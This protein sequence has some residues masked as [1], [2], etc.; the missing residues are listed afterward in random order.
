M[1]TKSNILWLLVLIPVSLFIIICSAYGD[2]KVIFHSPIWSLN[3][4]MAL[5]ICPDEN[6]KACRANIQ[7][8]ADCK[9]KLFS[10][11]WELKWKL[12]FSCTLLSP[13]DLQLL[14]VGQTLFQHIRLSRKLYR[15]DRVMG[16]SCLSFNLRFQT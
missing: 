9:Y 2:S 1:F 3:I 4:P 7:N 5:P 13:S 10:S 11:V 16:N 6:S 15:F 8:K 14:I 12:A